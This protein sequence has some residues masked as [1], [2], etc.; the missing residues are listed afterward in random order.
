MSI[1]KTLSCLA[2]LTISAFG[3][4][5]SKYFGAKLIE[6]DAL[7]AKSDTPSAHFYLKDANQTIARIHIRRFKGI[8]KSAVEYANAKADSYVASG[9]SLIA[10][11]SSGWFSDNDSS[12]EVASSTD[13]N[14]S[15]QFVRM[16]KAGNETYAITGSM[17]AGLKW[18]S[19]GEKIKTLIQSFKFN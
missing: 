6:L 8:P 12:F 4:D 10:K 19:V 3:G 16:M 14:V 13:E 5:D 11:P 1:Y 9:F 18:D 17:S 7:I 2:V 15:H